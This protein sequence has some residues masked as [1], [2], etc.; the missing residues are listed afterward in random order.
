M[1]KKDIQLKN[2][3]PKNFKNIDDNFDELY[4]KI[5][6]ESV[7]FTPQVLT[8]DQQQ[9]AR[10]NIGAAD[11]SKVVTINTDQTISGIKTFSTDTTFLG[12][13]KI[14]NGNNIGQIQLAS[15]MFSAVLD[16]EDIS[17]AVGIVATQIS[18]E[19]FVEVGLNTV[20]KLYEK[21]SYL[22]SPVRVYSPNNP[23]PV[24]IPTNMVTTDT[25]QTIS[26]AKTFNA[27]L[28]VNSSITGESIVAKTTDFGIM[29]MAPTP[30]GFMISTEVNGDPVGILIFD[31][32]FL[33]PGNSQHGLVSTLAYYEAN[34]ETAEVVRVYSPNNKPK[35]ADIGAATTE[36]V[37]AKYTKPSTG[38]PKTDLASSVQTSLN[39]ADT[40]LQS[41]PV[42]SVA[43]KTG[44]VTLTKSDVGLSNVDNV[45]QFP[46]DGGTITNSNSSGIVTII[47]NANYTSGSEI[48][49][50]IVKT[51]ATGNTFSSIKFGTEGPNG[52]TMLRFDQTDGTPRLLFR[53]SSTAGSIVWQQPE[54]NSSLYFDVNNIYYRS[55]G[56][57]LNSTALYPTTTNTRDLGTSSVRWKNIYA[58]QTIHTNG[59]INAVGQVQEN[60]TRVYSPNNKPTPTDIGAQPAGDY[61]TTA[62]VNAKYTKPAAGI[63]KSDLESS[64]Q[65]SLTKADTA[66]QS[67]PSDVVRTGNNQSITGQKTFGD[68][69]LVITDHADFKSSDMDIN[70]NPSEEKF[71]YFNGKDKNGNMLGAIGFYQDPVGNTGA[72][73]QANHG[74]TWGGNLGIKTKAGS[75][76]VFAYAPNPPSNSS[77]NQ[78]ATTYWV[79][80]KISGKFPGTGSSIRPIYITTLGNPA[81]I[82]VSDS[83]ASSALTSSDDK[84]ATVRD[85]YYGTPTINGS[86]TY[87]SATNIYAPTSRGNLNQLLSSQGSSN[88]PIFEYFNECAYYS[89]NL[90]NS[91]EKYVQFN[92]N[93]SINS[94]MIQA[95]TKTAGGS[96]AVDVAITFPK[97]FYSI[98]HVVATYYAD[99]STQ[100]YY[101]WVRLLS[102]SGFTCR[103]YSGYKILWIAIGVGQI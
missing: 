65:T 57:T 100:N 26:G 35:P 1:A 86:K 14:Q 16:N 3:V 19:G 73:L 9:Q 79:D 43:G 58:Q 83:T 88:N 44:A 96:G 62:Q 89:Y 17:K 85:I 40:A 77:T 68:Y 94:L 45:K 29:T 48:D 75:T 90:N 38:I 7:K 52:G 98:P 99:A 15:G 22:S 5:D 84:L 39:K 30:E 66:L 2:T 92:A 103:G 11:A 18:A 81:Q 61:A 50:L 28:N 25:E 82:T 10:T 60:G 69:D 102:K 67:I 32:G 33:L 70:T 76:D 37:N 27:A 21:E 64:V 55:A 8:V 63:P 23:P 101:S 46:M 6:A 42:T 31:T 34:M 59:N 72:Y 54:S 56:Y 13:I 93:S 95:G 71:V 12:D 51:K 20:G 91:T 47:N 41:A 80:Q 78:I 36:Q 24:S 49:T 74:A 97:S 87:T 53:G 4:S